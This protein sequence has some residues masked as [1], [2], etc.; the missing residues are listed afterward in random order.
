MWNSEMKTGC[1][2][3]ETT[4]QPRYQ[5]YWTLEPTDTLRTSGNLNCS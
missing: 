5:H 3:L 2:A 4:E 1:A